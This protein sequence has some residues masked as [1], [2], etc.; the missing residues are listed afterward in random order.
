MTSTAFLVMKRRLLQSAT[1][2]EVGLAPRILSV[3]A[4]ALAKTLTGIA[5][6]PLTRSRPMTASFCAGDRLESRRVLRVSW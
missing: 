6:T 2:A 5:K 1:I 3:K 4:A